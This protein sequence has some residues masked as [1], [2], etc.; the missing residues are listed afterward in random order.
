LKIKKNLIAFFRALFFSKWV[1][2]GRFAYFLS[3]RAD[4][5]TLKK[6]WSGEAAAIKFARNP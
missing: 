1:N 3:S 5:H 2:F 4:P 6:S